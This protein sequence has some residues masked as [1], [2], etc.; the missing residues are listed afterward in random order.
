MEMYVT[1]R[2]RN[3][4]FS[5]GTSTPNIINEMK[6]MKM[7]L[8]VLAVYLICW[9]PFAVV[10]GTIEQILSSLEY[11]KVLYIVY[12]VKFLQFMNS[13]CNPFVYA[14]FYKCFRIGVKDVLLSCFC[15]TATPAPD[16][17]PQS[18]T[19]RF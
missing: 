2:N 8:C 6:I 18:Q 9:L 7:I 13:T 4:Q 19:T 17:E 15:K 1:I 11:S 12:A 3:K 14:I 5:I 10:N 16:I